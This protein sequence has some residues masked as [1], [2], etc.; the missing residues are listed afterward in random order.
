MDHSHN[1]GWRYWFLVVPDRDNGEVTPPR[2][3]AVPALDGGG[4][5]QRAF[6]LI[7]VDI[8]ETHEHAGEG[9][10]ALRVDRVVNHTGAIGQVAAVPAGKGAEN[11]DILDRVVVGIA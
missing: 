4:C 5:E 11:L 7:C 8:D 1:W 6:R 3:S 2:P 10:L 9:F